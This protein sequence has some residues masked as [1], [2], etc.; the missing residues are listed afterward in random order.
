M[1][2]GADQMVEA[3]EIGRRV[4][5]YRERLGFRQAELAKRA[6]RSEA[7]VNRLENGLVRSPKIGDLGVIARALD[8]TLDALI[9]GDAPRTEEDILAAL[10]RQPRFALAMASL[11]KGL[12]MADA[13]D[14]EF[15]IGHLESLAR[16]FG[17]RAFGQ[18]A[19]DATDGAL[20]PDVPG[21]IASAT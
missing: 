2:D 9:Y 18:S 4:T 15:V 20:S 12:Q 1:D 3:R 8:V 19:A 16:R 7:Y 5:R 6:G 13:D 10:A 11:V 14:R 17:D 21:D